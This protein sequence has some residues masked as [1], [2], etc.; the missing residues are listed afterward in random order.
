M[1]VITLICVTALPFSNHLNGIFDEHGIPERFLS[2]NGPQYA[3][4]EFKQFAI[5]Y[6]FEHVTSSP[7]YARCNGFAERMV[8]TMKRLF[9][10][11][12]D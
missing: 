7:I 8:Q 4:E 3:S 11:A 12:R 5:D 9:T 6:G 10:K 2:D 1:R